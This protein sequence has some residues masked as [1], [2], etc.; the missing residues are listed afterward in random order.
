MREAVDAVLRHRVCSSRKYGE[1]VCAGVCQ[2]ANTRN[3]IQ[4]RQG[5]NN[6]GIA[7]GSPDSVKMMC[8]S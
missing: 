8:G 3:N 1:M 5:V 7:G 2:D 4:I 6:Y